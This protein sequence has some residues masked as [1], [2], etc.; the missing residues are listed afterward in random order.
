M[1]TKGTVLSVNVSS[2]KGVVKKPV[3]QIDINDLGIVGD[4]HAGQWQRQVSLLSQEQIDRFAKETGKDIQPGQ[5]A[6]NLTVKGLHLNSVSVL[7]HF[8]IGDVRRA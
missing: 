4:A 2:E 8:Q 5:F 7:D 6:E 3:S 1:S